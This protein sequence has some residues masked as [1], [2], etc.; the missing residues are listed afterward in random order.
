VKNKATLPQHI[1]GPEDLV[2]PHAAVRDGFLRQALEKTRRANPHVAEA[3][4]LLEALQ[5]VSKIEKLL[6]ITE[7]RDDLAAASGLSDKAQS[8]VDD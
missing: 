6:S 8:R 5:S 3:R 4:R 1:H 7:F 2:T